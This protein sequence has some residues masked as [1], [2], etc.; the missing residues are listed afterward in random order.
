MTATAFAPNATLTHEQGYAIIVRWATK[1]GGA[2]LGLL[3]DA[4]AMAMGNLFVATATV[5]GDDPLDATITA[6]EPGLGASNEI[7][8]PLGGTTRIQAAAALIR[9]ARLLQSVDPSR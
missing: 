6:A 5:L 8:D 1:A 7:I 2:E 9:A 4:P 3:G